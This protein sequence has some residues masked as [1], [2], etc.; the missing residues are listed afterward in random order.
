MREGIGPD[1]QPDAQEDARFLLRD[2][3]LDKGVRF[4]CGTLLGMLMVAAVAITEVGLSLGG[5]VVLGALFVSACGILAV[6]QGERFIRGL[7][8][9]TGWL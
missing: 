3:V 2:T 6:S 1:A 9:L 4:G 5:T 8:R 7:L